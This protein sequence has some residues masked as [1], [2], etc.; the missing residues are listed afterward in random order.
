ML[1]ATNYCG[2][3]YPPYSTK[4]S[5]NVSETHSKAWA[6]Q[7]VTSYTIYLQRKESNTPKYPHASTMSSQSLWFLS[8]QS[9]RVLIYRTMTLVCQE[10]QVR[11]DFSYQDSLRD[12]MVLLRDRVVA[13]HLYPKRVQRN[14]PVFSTPNTAQFAQNPSQTLSSAK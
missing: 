11:A 12:R 8:E 13:D 3:R 9:A 5:T 2:H 1:Q 7:Y 4:P 10:Y 6:Q 14:D